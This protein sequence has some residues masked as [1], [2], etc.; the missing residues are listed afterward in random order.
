[1]ADKKSYTVNRAMH[2]DG[3]DYERGDTRQMAEA[4]AAALVATGALSE[5]GKAAAEPAPAVVHTF[6]QEPSAV[7]DAGYTT[8]TRDGIIAGRPAAASSAPKA[9]VTA[10]A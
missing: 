5:K 2:G 4:D 6:G 3:K 10:K 9:K 8:A 1:M 7:N